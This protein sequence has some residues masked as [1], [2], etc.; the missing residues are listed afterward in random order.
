LK[1]KDPHIF[2][3]SDLDSPDEWYA[4]LATQFDNFRFSATG[5]IQDPE[6]VDIALIW[7]IPDEGLERFANLRAVLSLGAGVSQLETDRLPN[8]GRVPIARL[9]DISLTRTM[10]DYARATVY[11][12]HRKLHVFEQ[13]SRARRWKF[14]RP[15]LTRDTCVGILGLGEIGREIA[16]ALERDGFEVRGWSRTPKELEGIVTCTGLEALGRM[17]GC[18]DIVINV[19]PLT[20]ET[21]HIL[22]KDLFR[23]F[24]DGTCLINMGRG[25]HLVETDLLA[26]IDA[27]KIAAATLDVAAIEPL[28]PG[29]Q[30]WN[31]PAILITPHVAGC[32]L[33]MSAV[34]PIADNIRRAMKGEPLKHQVDLRRGF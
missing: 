6:S 5:R 19:L 12:Y 7:T 1:T 8:P 9:V 20:P 23:H 18:S 25:M 33:P 4:A 11:R 27:G 28:P 26:A 14:I 29:H 22:S 3:H 31:H 17:V 30:F 21:R 16:R 2:F 34:V 15:T 32:S 10:I 24:R 13:H